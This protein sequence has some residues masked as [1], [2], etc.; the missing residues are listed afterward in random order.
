[1]N[2]TPARKREISSRLRRDQDARPAFVVRQEKGA[3][4]RR[5]RRLH[6]KD[7]VLLGI[8]A[9]FTL[10][11][12]LRAAY[13]QGL[14]AVTAGSFFLERP[15]VEEPLAAARLETKVR[16]R[17][18]G[19]V[20]EVEVNQNFVNESGEFAEG[21]YAFPLPEDAAVNRLRMRIGSRLIEGEIREKRAAA[22]VYREARAAGKR[23]SLLTQERPNLFTSRVANLPPGET[24]EV[25][26]SYVQELSYRD[27]GFSLRFPM[28]LAPRYEPG[29]P[30]REAIQRTLTDEPVS[31]P[32]YATAPGT[33]RVELQIQLDAGFELTRLESL[34]HD[35]SVAE[36]N[37]RYAI[38][39]AAGEV[40]PERD[41]ELVWEPSLKQAP[42]AALFSEADADGAYALLMVMPPQAD[43]PEQRPRELVLVID[44]SGSMHGASLEQARESLLMALGSLSPDD[45]FNVISFNSAPTALFPGARLADDQA[46]GAAIDFVEDLSAGGGTEIAAA[47]D[48]ALGGAAAPGYLRQVVFITDG[49]VANE[50]EL[51]ARI[52]AQLGESR[53]F[54]VG[55][56]P[57][58][59]GY[60]MRKAAQFGRGSYTFIGSQEQVAERMDGLLRRLEHP[61]LTE[62]CVDWPGLSE[63]YPFRPGDLYLGEPLMI[64]ARLDSLDGAAEVCGNTPLDAWSAFVD[65]KADT[66]GAGIASLWARRKIGTLMDDLALGADPTEIR[67]ETLAV[68]L[69]HRLVSRY[70]SFVAVDKTPVRP[71]GLPLSTGRIANAAL[72]VALPA[73]ATDSGLRIAFGL[74]LIL[75]GWV[76][77]RRLRDAD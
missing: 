23:A 66:P 5:R 18:S 28:A 33:N 63:M 74:M 4:P 65:L 48:L 54:T 69:K 42:Q 50:T 27:G 15:G 64:A 60:F 51:F 73:T 14:D 20:A 36:S 44:T 34:Y 43:Y 76:F 22:E 12:G 53:L 35:V 55:I 2:R 52:E 46:I 1:M 41:F 26:I 32:V 70:T 56:G 25:Q 13:A 68:A 8:L 40:P 71:A 29:A 30:E 3:A 10:A 45:R 19:M 38:E 39:L 61:V 57:A 77:A 37:G 16:M 11:L 24:I 58:P 75:T 47:L 17:V 67:A 6:Y 72:A 62:V 9:Y 49:S 21:I 7:R 59:N 31:R